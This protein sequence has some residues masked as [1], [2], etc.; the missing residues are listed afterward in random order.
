MLGGESLD[1]FPRGPNADWHVDPD[2]SA[3][4]VKDQYREEIRRADAVLRMTGL[5]APPAQPDPDWAR[6][7]M[8]FPDA[9]SIV[10]HMITETAVHA[11]HLDAVRELIDGHQHIVL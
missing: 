9:R 5:N 7:G 1:Y 11:G 8:D 3:E 10:L 4:S 2:R 6:Y